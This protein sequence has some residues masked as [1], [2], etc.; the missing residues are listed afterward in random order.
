[1][2]VDFQAGGSAEN[3]LQTAMAAAGLG[4]GRDGAPPS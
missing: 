4:A 3:A 1:V 2:G